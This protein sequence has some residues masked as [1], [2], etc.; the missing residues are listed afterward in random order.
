MDALEVATEA[1]GYERLNLKKG[2]IRTHSIHS[3]AAMAMYLGEVPVYS[4]MMIGRWSSNVFLRYIRKQ[5]GQF[6]HNVS[7]R[8]ITFQ[9]F[10]HIPKQDP[11]ISHQDPRQRNH[12]SNTK[13]RQNV[14]VTRPAVLA[15]PRSR[16]TTDENFVLSAPSCG[17][18]GKSLVADR[19]GEGGQIVLKCNSKA[20]L[21]V[22]VTMIVYGKFSPF[23]MAHAPS[24][25]FDVLAVGFRS[26]C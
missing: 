20:H 24:C 14:G 3:G 10:R 5:V 9:Y 4:I 17:V 11:R 1:V 16:S 6:S 19:I 18:N 8:M 22:Y 12:P 7:K 25:A 15:C 26:V 21:C 13:T 2:D 23:V